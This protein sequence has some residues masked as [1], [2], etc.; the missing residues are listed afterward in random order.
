MEF[1]RD[2]EMRFL[3][4]KLVGKKLKQNSTNLT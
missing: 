4:K 3:E 2:Q 1:E